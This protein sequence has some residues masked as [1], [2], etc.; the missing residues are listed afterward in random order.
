MAL[1]IIN[2]LIATTI[3]FDDFQYPDGTKLQDITSLMSGKIKHI[4]QPNI[5]KQPLQLKTPILKQ[6]SQLKTPKSFNV[7][8]ATGITY[9][10]P[11]R[12]NGEIQNRIV[13]ATYPI[14]YEINLLDKKIYNSTFTI[15]IK[16]TELPSYFLIQTFSRFNKNVNVYEFFYGNMDLN[17]MAI[18]KRVNGNNFF[19]GG[20]DFF[21]T[22]F[23]NLLEV[24]FIINN[25]NLQAYENNNLRINVFD[26]QPHEAGG[27]AFR[28]IGVDNGLYP[29][30]RRR[31][32]IKQINIFTDE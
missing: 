13:Y 16:S 32:G 9:L 1:G 6:V 2:F 18:Y 8:I 7:Y 23:Y 11:I 28:F 22:I 12:L 27:F 26:T 4:K 19:L 24:K 10:Y 3:F 17:T 21:E 30:D 20:F 14:F 31:I 25:N 5:L 15:L 29:T